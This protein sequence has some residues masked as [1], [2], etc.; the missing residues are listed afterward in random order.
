M[1]R[2]K[3]IQGFINKK[4]VNKFQ[5]QVPNTLYI[6]DLGGVI[7]DKPKVLKTIK[8]YVDLIT[9]NIRLKDVIQTMDTP[10]RYSDVEYK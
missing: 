2:Y 3:H 5:H 1:K 9:F 10:K 7:R 8:E 4:T 6:V